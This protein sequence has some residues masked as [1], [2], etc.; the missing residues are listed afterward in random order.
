MTRAD[1]VLHLAAL[2]ARRAITQPQATALL[3]AFDNGELDNG[4]LPTLSPPAHDGNEW[5]IALLAVLLLTRANTTR[6]LSAA[7][8]RQARTTLRATFEANMGA[9]AVAV[10]TARLTVGAWQ[11]IM[12]KDIGSYSRQ[13]AVAGAGTLPGAATQAAVE[14]GL[15]EQ[16]PYLQSFALVLATKGTALAASGSVVRTPTEQAAGAIVVA[17][18]PTLTGQALAAGVSAKQIAARSKLYGSTGWASYW[19]G[20]A[21]TATN[22]GS[23]GWLIHFRAKDDRATCDRCSD[24]AAGSP[25]PADEAHPIPGEVC[26]GAGSCRCEL[27]FEFSPATYDKLT[28]RQAA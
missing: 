3:E 9:L 22:D 13:M 11:D 15:A 25:Y 1:L 19:K 24:A 18:P 28:G 16:W 7:K 12:Q 17:T 21:A 20:E 23:Y 8:R 2:V 27:E 10:T 5:P 14:A 26:E 6:P 4:D